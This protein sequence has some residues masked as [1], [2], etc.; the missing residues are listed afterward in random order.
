MMSNTFLTPSIIAKEALMVLRNNLVFANLV[1][2]DYSSEFAAK[3]GDTITI[4]KPAT[5]EAKE[6]DA[7]S[8]ISVQDVTE[9]GVAVKLDKHLDV[10][11]EITSKERALELQD[12]SQ[13]VL[14]PAMSAFGQKIDEYL[15]GLYVDIP[16]YTGTPGTTPSTAADIA[17][18]GKVLN[19]NKA[20]MRD[21]QL[22][23]DPEAQAKLIVLDSFMEV[24]KA[25]TTEAL[26]NANLGRLLG[27]DTYM[28]QNIKAH[29]I[30]TLSA[31]EGNV[32]TKGAVAAGKTEAVFDST[33][34][35]GTLKKGDLF[36]VEDA[37]GIY[38]VTEAATAADN[39]IT[40]KFYPAAPG[41]ADGKK[42]T[43]IA[44]HTANLAFHKNA[45]ALV[46]RPLE[47]PAGAANAA[48]VSY[49]GYV[50]RVVMD[51]D[52]SKKKDVVSID[53]LCGVKTLTPELAC[54]LVG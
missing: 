7:T 10:S 49:D 48:I 50:L 23:I 3:V 41:F 9:Q 22:V 15:A 5:F 54:R 43:V 33:T 18:C 39:E 32:L 35:T 11:F 4:R 45:F 38:T 12:F 53:M 46:T 20:P 27:F 1:H 13:Q 31:G 8:G 25:G 40:V 30:G 42:V 2:R 16:Y 24:D 37:K 21:R 44:N 47:L 34:L 6:F 19:I 14:V 52:I 51:Y 17:N 28:D 29:T 26:R 36:T